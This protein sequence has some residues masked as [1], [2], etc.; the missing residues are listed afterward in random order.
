MRLGTIV[1]SKGGKFVSITS[2]D[3]SEVK[4]IFKKDSF[5]GYDRVY[6]FDSSGGM[7][8]KRGEV[9]KSK[10]VASLKKK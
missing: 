6:F 4:S 3:A 5:K 9:V 1:G 2:G 7:T 10:P 8:K